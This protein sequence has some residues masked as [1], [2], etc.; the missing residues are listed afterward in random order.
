MGMTNE[1]LQKNFADLRSEVEQPVV[2]AD[3]EGFVVYINHQ[4]TDA[5]L[6]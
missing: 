1:Q 6:S 2:I 4:F 3:D 5:Y